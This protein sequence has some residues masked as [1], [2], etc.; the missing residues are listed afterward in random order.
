M[1]SLK[2]SMC[3]IPGDL[4]PAKTPCFTTVVNSGRINACA[5]SSA[6]SSCKEAEMAHARVVSD[7]YQ[8]QITGPVAVCG[9]D[10]PRLLLFER[11]IVEPGEGVT[12][13]YAKFGSVR[14]ASA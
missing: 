9:V 10:E 3:F 5:G 12:F 14:E 1:E 2:Y 11:C 7:T 13:T 6:L 4:D 8:V